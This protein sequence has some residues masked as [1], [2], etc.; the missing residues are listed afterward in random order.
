MGRPPE[1][2]E[3]EVLERAMRV[4]WRSGFEATSLDDL[5]EATG[6]G[7]QSLYNRFG[8]KR[9]LFLRCLRHYAERFEGTV[10]GLLERERPVARAFELLFESVLSEPDEQKRRGC[11]LINSAMELSPRDVEVGDLIARSQGVIQELFQDALQA[12]KARGELPR[13]FQPQPVARF[14]LGA[15]LGLTVLQKSDPRSGAARDMVQVT[16]RVL[17]P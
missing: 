13:G 7:R 10:R 15:L 2:D 1:F 11:L 17:V 9:A 16:L 14:L 3:A 6:V 4:F 8:E 5:V 12:G